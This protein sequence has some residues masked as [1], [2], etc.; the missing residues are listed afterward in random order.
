MLYSNRWIDNFLITL[1]YFAVYQQ[2][3]IIKLYDL[4]LLGNLTNHGDNFRININTTTSHTMP[5]DEA[6]NGRIEVDNPAYS[7]TLPNDNIVERNPAYAG[8][9]IM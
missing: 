6:D 9:D 2:C 4:L 5:N 7:G 3:H 1:N 8:S